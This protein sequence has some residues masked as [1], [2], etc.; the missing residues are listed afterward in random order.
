[1]YCEDE[2]TAVQCAAQGLME[3]TARTGCEYCALILRGRKGWRALRPIRGLH[4]NVILPAVLMAVVSLFAR[5]AALLHTHPYCSCHNG[6][7]FS[8]HRDERG[9]IAS[10]GDVCVPCMGR[11]RR[12]W[13]ASPAGVL[14][15]WDGRGEVRIAARLA[16]PKE[17]IRFSSKWNGLLP[18]KL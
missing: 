17:R 5:E 16:V 2:L 18:K 9:R 1:M 10:M 8:G 13:L 15:S 4:N 11:I 7:E 12:I 6:E 3:K 14:S